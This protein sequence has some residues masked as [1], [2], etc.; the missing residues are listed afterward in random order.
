MEIDDYIERIID[1]DDEDDMYELS[2]ILEDV[3][4]IIK[5][6]ELDL[7]YDSDL[8]SYEKA[9]SS[10]VSAIRGIYSKETPLRSSTRQSP[11]AKRRTV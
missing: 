7:E 2:D 11:R 6:N 3:L 5:K 4:E 8:K 9:F 10:H 1:K